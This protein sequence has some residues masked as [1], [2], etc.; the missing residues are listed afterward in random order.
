[1]FLFIEW[2][3]K[4]ALSRIS[5]DNFTGSHGGGRLFCLDEFWTDAINAIIVGTSAAAIG[6][7]LNEKME[8]DLKI[9]VARFRIFEQGFTLRFC[10]TPRI[11]AIPG[12]KSEPFFCFLFPAELCGVIN[13]SKNGVLWG[14]RGSASRTTKNGTR[15]Q[16]RVRHMPPKASARPP[17]QE[18]DSQE[19]R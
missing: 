3:K 8:Q 19:Q 14:Y 1:M 16:L 9:E 7:V 6:S 17:T 12:L 13:D 18:Q 11:A 2:R 5:S 10:Q 15:A 4:S